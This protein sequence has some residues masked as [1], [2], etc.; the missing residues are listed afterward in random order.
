[1][2]VLYVTT[3]WVSIE[4][5]HFFVRNVLNGLIG[6]GVDIT[7]MSLLGATAGEVAIKKNK[8]QTIDYYRIMVDPRI[9]VQQT[10]K[11]LKEQYSCIEP[12]VIHLNGY[13]ISEID[14]AL[15]LKIPVVMTVH[16]GGIL[17][18]GGRGFLT[19]KDEICNVSV[20]QE[21]CYKCCIRNFP[22]WQFWWVL[23]SSIPIKILIRL[24][25]VI[26]NRK[27]VPIF[28]PAFMYS[29]LIAEKI[30]FVE[31][32]QSVSAIIVAST[33]LKEA[34]ERNGIKNNLALIPHG[35]PNLK[36]YALPE[37]K[38]KIK[39][40]YLG[41]IEYSKGIHIM[42]EAFKRIDCQKYELHIIGEQPG[43]SRRVANYKKYVF[44]KSRGLN[45]FWYGSVPYKKIEEFIA[46]FHV[47]IH[48]A[49]YL[50]VFGTSISESLSIGRPVLSTRCG[51]AEMQII[52]GFN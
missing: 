10:T 5:E 29:D 7:L 16:E 33:K 42:I 46:Q 11:I 50:E 20:S 27:F 39:F 45:V 32:L 3:T 13:Y 8:Y 12:D 6:R 51:G 22:A 17:C 49:I 35:V 28:S 19:W 18:P 21:N 15:E 44:K 9:S 2:R 40:F 4:R 30:A 36:R 1:M 37:V 52:D 31:K 26:K 25:S 34:F 43:I 41:R 38:E 14:A 23:F 24:G 48:P 47:M